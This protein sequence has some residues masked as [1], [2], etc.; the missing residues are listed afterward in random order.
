MNPTSQIEWIPVTERMPTEKGRKYLVASPGTVFMA[1]RVDSRW[2]DVIAY[3]QSSKEAR[4]YVLG[5]ITHWAEL[6]A[7]LQ[8]VAETINTIPTVDPN[9]GQ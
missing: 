8:S 7:L 5:G 9:S 2:L 6:P 1:T 3:Y 4:R